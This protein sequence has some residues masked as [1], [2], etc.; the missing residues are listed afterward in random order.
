MRQKDGARVH[1]WKFLGVRGT[2]AR[3]G[4]GPPAG[5]GASL[6]DRDRGEQTEGGPGNHLACTPWLSPLGWVGRG[7]SPCLPG[8]ATGGCC[9]VLEDTEREREGHPDLGRTTVV[10]NARGAVGGEGAP[11]PHRVSLQPPPLPTSLLQGPQERC[12]QETGEA[13][14]A[15]PEGHR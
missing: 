2:G 13:G 4:A 14:E 7:A 8:A 15:D 6:P 11:G 5:Q 10:P 3:G 9:W 12:G 1:V